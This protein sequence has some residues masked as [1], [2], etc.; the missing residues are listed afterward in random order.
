MH[1]GENLHWL[2]KRIGADEF[3]VDF[4]DAFEFAEDRLAADFLDDVAKIEIDHVPAADAE[5]FLANLE[6]FPRGDVAGDEVAILGIFFLEEVIA[7]LLRDEIRAG[8]RFG[9][10]LPHAVF[11]FDSGNPDAAAFPAGG[12]ADQAAFILAGDGGGMHLDKFRIAVASAGLIAARVGPAGADDRHGALAEDQ[13]IAARG[14]HDRIGAKRANLH[15]PHVLGDDADAGRRAANVLNHRPEEFPEFIFVNAAFRFEP[16]HL[17][18]EGVE[19]LLPRRCAGEKC[20][21]D[22]A[23]TKKPKA[24]L[25]LGRAIEGYA[26]AIE[27][28]DDPR[29]PIAHLVDRRLIREKISAENRLV[30]VNPFAVTLLS[31]DVVAGVDAALGADTVAALHR[32][33]R[34]KIDVDMLLGQLHR[35]RQPGQATSDDDHAMFRCGHKLLMCLASHLPSL[36]RFARMN[37]R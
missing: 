22:Q 9:V 23:P 4:E 24:A 10:G 11:V 16:P 34:E 36:A 2:S 19:Q 8:R 26:H 18:V 7:F 3:F 25:P 35:A 6:D 27:Q 5:A 29:G 14:D 31:R 32:H 17:L 15:R 30:E 33:H 12:F 1:G 28:I 20:A 21:L 13:S 37:F